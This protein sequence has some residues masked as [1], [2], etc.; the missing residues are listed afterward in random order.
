MR[1]EKGLFA[2]GRT[3]ELDEP[4]ET[5]ILDEDEEDLFDEDEEDLEEIS[6]DE[7]DDAA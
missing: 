7:E 4:I 3:E 5:D 2:V 1:W 6:E